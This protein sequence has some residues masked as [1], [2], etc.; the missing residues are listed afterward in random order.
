MYD[1]TDPT[2]HAGG[3][4]FHPRTAGQSLQVN[5]NDNDSDY[6]KNDNAHCQDIIIV[7]LKHTSIQIFLTNIDV[8][9][10]GIEKRRDVLT[11]TSPPLSQSLTIIGFVTAIIYLKSEYQKIFISL[12]FLFCIYYFAFIFTFIFYTHI[13]YFSF[14]FYYFQC[15]LNRLTLSALCGQKSSLALL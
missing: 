8:I 9:K 14:K 3:P 15:H 4:E 13:C 7:S 1:P 5:D 10:G 12:F 2:P 6:F 11:F